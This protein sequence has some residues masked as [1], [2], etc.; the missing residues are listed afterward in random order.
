MVIRRLGCVYLEW[1]SETNERDRE[2][3]KYRKS[4]WKLFLTYSL[5]EA[6]MHSLYKFSQ[7]LPC[8]RD[9]HITRSMACVIAYLW[10]ASNVS[11]EVFNA[12]TRIKLL[13]LAANK[14]VIVQKSIYFFA[15]FFFL[16]PWLFLYFFKRKGRE[17][18]MMFIWWIFFS[19]VFRFYCLWDVFVYFYFTFLMVYLLLL[20]L[21]SIF[22]FC[23]LFTVC[24][25]V[26]NVSRSVRTYQTHSDFFIYIIQ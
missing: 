19:L 7:F 26:W 4:D 17:K 5:E 3:K 23:L 11:D 16:N 22:F 25:V 15:F 9:L 18:T 24:W 21:L 6:S 20:A 14:I 13:F 1:Y 12:R 10:I 8:P 2:Y